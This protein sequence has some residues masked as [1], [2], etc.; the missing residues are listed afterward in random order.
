MWKRN[1]AAQE[2]SKNL[3]ARTCLFGLYIIIIFSK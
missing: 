2:N 1:A 3:A